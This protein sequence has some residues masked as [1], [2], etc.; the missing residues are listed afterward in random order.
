MPYIGQNKSMDARR[1]SAAIDRFLFWE[2]NATSTIENFFRNVPNRQTHDVCPREA[3]VQTLT[4]DPPSGT[5]YRAT[6]GCA[7]SGCTFMP[8][9]C[10][11]CAFR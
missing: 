2:Y 8:T 1:L 6:L 5:H 7:H 11:V 9:L 10:M 3:S 4:A